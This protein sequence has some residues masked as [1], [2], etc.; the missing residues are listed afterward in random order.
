MHVLFLVLILYM[1]WVLPGKQPLLPLTNRPDTGLGAALRNCSFT[2][3]GSW[4]QACC[5]L[6]AASAGLL[7]PTLA[8]PHPSIP[9]AQ[10]HDGT[11]RFR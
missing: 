7:L 4:L 8:L 9:Q 2:A 5:K 11:C 3:E 1:L 6:A 10:S